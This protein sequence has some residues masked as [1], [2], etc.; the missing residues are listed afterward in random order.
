MKENYDPWKILM[1]PI[2]NNYSSMVL[3]FFGRKKA[4]W[5]ASVVPR[6]PKNQ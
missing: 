3:T 4:R 5:N 1:F 2:H 6:L